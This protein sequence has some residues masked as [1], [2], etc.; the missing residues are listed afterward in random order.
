[1]HKFLIYFFIPELTCEYAES[2]GVY[3]FNVPRNKEL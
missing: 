1:M 3:K 2:L